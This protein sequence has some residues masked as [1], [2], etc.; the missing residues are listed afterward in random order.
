VD[1]TVFY[2]VHNIFKIAVLWELDE[3]AGV[4]IGLGSP[5]LGRHGDA[6]TEPAQG[7]LS[8]REREP[9]RKG[10]QSLV[11]RGSLVGEMN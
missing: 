9:C 4:G 8:R 2:V 5:F 7:G 6:E 3:G 11:R 1:D 10:K